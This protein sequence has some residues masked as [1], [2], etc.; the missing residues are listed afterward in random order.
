MTREHLLFMHWFKLTAFIPKL[1]PRGWVTKSSTLVQTNIGRVVR[2]EQDL[3]W[4]NT[5]SARLTRQ[6][7]SIS[8]TVL[9]PFKD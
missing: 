9:V 8:I 5:S 2:R 1:H 7:H 3:V 6:C 4:E